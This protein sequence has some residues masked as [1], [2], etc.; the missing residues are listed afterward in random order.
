MS[1]SPMPSMPSSA[2]AAVLCAAALGLAAAASPAHADG[3]GPSAW[4]VAPSAGEGTRPAKDGRPSFYA[5]GAP[6]AVLHDTVAVTNPGPR[7]RTVSLRGAD[8]GGSGSGAWIRFGERRVE[9]PPR[10]RAEVP[11]TVTVP[12]GAVPGDHPGM[13]VASVG[14]RTERV[15][16]HLRV[17]GP[18]LAALTIEHVKVSEA[19]KG[20][21][22]ITYD[23]VN[24]GNTVLAPKLA[25]HAEGVF[26]TLVDRPPRTLP[27]ELPPGRRV[28]LT[29]P[30]PDAPA[31]DA[32]SV[33]LTV[34]APGGARDS[35]TASARFVPWG[36]VAGG[37][38]GLL[39]VAGGAFHVVRGRRRD[40]EVPEPAGEQGQ[41]PCAGR[42]LAEVGTGT[43]PG[44]GGKQ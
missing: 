44:A 35:A 10:T 11:F 2:R 33:R 1:I 26:G 12:P 28:S 3:A 21:K 32:A 38:A 13:I 9:V 5:E 31:L 14:G 6:G 34:S 40:S 23:L 27:V 16:L 36:A 4:S 18:T 17:E 39:A 22:R 19:D 8:A 20:G 25:V 24:R 7:P 37:G 29:E 15:R 30:W 41:E 42:E 43:G